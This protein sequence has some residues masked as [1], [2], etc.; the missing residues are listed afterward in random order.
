MNVI[1]FGQF[2]KA[3]EW[4][5]RE[6]NLQPG[7]QGAIA[8][9]T[10][11]EYLEKAREMREFSLIVGQYKLLD[12]QGAESELAEEGIFP[13]RRIICAASVSAILLKWASEQFYDGVI[14]LT[15]Y[16]KTFGADAS[17]LLT[18]K[19]GHGHANV[20][21]PLTGNVPSMIPYRDQIDKDIVRLISYGF[22]NEEIADSIFLSLQ[23]VRNRIS[24]L[25]QTSGARNRTH[26]STMYLLLHTSVKDGEIHPTLSMGNEIPIDRIDI[27]D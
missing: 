13:Q 17:K 10:T 12:Y 8:V 7:F 14:D 24:R 4:M 6:I 27:R 15:E 16:Q 9:T 22:S 20:S 26:L 11:D 1:V 21:F 18:L 23:T 2:Q 19:R 25:L 3:C 5:A